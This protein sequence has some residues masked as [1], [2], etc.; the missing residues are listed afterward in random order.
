MRPP[1]RTRRWG[2]RQ[3]HFPNLTTSF[4]TPE[5]VVKVRTSYTGQY[6]SPVLNRKSGQ[7]PGKTAVAEKRKKAG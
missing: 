2:A 1:R 6:L 5:D 3:P 4:R 7:N